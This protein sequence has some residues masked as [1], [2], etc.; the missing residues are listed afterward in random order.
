MSAKTYSA[1]A[2]ADLGDV[3]SM[4]AF[5][6]DPNQD[7]QINDNGNVTI[8]EGSVDVCDDSETSRNLCG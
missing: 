4:T 2:L 1:P 5:F 7:D 3:R 8:G 6:N